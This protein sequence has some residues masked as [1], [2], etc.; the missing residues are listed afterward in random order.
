MNR[1]LTVQVPTVFRRWEVVS[2]VAMI[3]TSGGKYTWLH[4]LVGTLISHA[5]IMDTHNMLNAALQV[6]LPVQ[7]EN[8]LSVRRFGFLR[9]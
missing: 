5:F 1:P 7:R 2:A 6:F 3:L 9:S 8:S 4:A